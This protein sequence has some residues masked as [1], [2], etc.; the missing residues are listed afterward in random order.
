MEG[1]SVILS[2]VRTLNMLS[3]LFAY[4]LLDT[5]VQNSIAMDVSK[6]KLV[7]RCPYCPMA[8]ACMHMALPLCMQ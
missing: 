7:F 2:G 5:V 1:V 8:P 3:V 4:I 6:S